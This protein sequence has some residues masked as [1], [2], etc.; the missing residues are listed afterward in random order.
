MAARHQATSAI[1]IFMVAAT[2][3]TLTNAD[4]SLFAYALPGIL[5][6]FRQPLDTAGVI[7]TVSFV[8]AAVIL[9]PIGLAADRWGRGIVL[10]VLLAS[11]AVMVAL[12][13]IATGVVTLTIFRALGFGLSSGLSP[14]TNV[15]A[16]EAAPP[17]LR[18]LAVGVLQCG[19]PLGWLL[20]SLAAA[21]LLA[22]GGWRAICLVALAV[23]PLSLLLAWIL[24]RQHALFAPAPTDPALTTGEMNTLSRISRLFAR[25]CLRTSLASIA[26]FFT[27]G[28]AYAG[29]AFFFPAFL[30]QARGYSEAEAAALVG[31]S[32]GIAIIGYLGA[33]VAGEFLITRRN[34]FAIWCV[35][36]AA[37]FAGLLWLST[38]RTT[39]LVW[40]S[41]MAAL[42]FGSQ[43]VMPVLL[44]ELFPA[45]VRT[46]ALALCA[47][48]PLSLG[49][50]VFPLVVPAVV[51]SRGW[52]MGLSIVV[53]PLLVAA[54]LIALLLPN[55]RS[56]LAATQD[57]PA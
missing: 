34:V 47:S 3:W 13:G 33:A 7:L 57:Q 18:G 26:I 51:A 49:F 5:A 45:E 52:P 44:A 14:I 10:V 37:A 21:P 46:T 11:S 15:M 9:V 29:S 39:D 35:A 12:Q 55:R 17:R 54:G 32:N 56:G 43:A 23:V 1:I 4:Q 8:L 20:A 19:Y 2:A 16:V 30:T 27:F 53:I 41:A 42:F 28:G 24:A 31:L 6:E 40:F 48:A 50:A 25:D 36:G 22:S 38:G